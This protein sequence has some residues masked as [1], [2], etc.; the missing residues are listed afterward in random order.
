MHAVRE[1]ERETGKTIKSIRMIRLDKPVILR[2]ASTDLV[3]IDVTIK[4]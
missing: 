1:F 4:E 3:D 2:G